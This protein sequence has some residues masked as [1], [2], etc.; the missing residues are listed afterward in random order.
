MASY[1]AQ[2]WQRAEQPNAGMPLP[3]GP[4][5]RVQ[6]KRLFLFSNKLRLGLTKPSAPT[7]AGVT[8]ARPVSIVVA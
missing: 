5:L 6:R 3:L 4:A 1:A 8:H 7:V 2:P